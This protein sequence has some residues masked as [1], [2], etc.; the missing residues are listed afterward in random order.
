MEHIRLGGRAIV[1]DPERKDFRQLLHY[2]PDALYLRAKEDDFDPMITNS[3]LPDAF[4]WN[5]NF[6]SAIGASTGMGISTTVGVEICEEMLKQGKRP[7]IPAV[8]R[9]IR[10]IKR[11]SFGVE[12]NHIMSVES[13]LVA[14]SSEG[15]L[16]RITGCVSGYPMTE[17]E[18]F[19]L[20]IFDISRLEENDA[21]LYTLMKLLQNFY[22]AREEGLGN[23]KPLLIC[24]DESHFIYGK[25]RNSGT[26]MTLTP[27]QLDIVKRARKV[28]IKIL[29]CTPNPSALIPEIFNTSMLVVFRLDNYQDQKAVQSALGLRDEELGILSEL[30]PRVA[31]ARI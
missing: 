13:R 29:L 3:S 5:K 10:S 21:F 23:G 22:W 16:G 25:D 26:Y 28:N 12:R 20:I 18:K 8:L 17:L 6:W 9:K 14:L 31:V 11:G 19:P 30:P 2:V 7:T 1:F 24:I 27:P 15:G 4:E